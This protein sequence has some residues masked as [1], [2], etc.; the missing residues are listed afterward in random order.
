MPNCKLQWN[1]RRHKLVL[2]LSLSLLLSF[3]P[4]LSLSLSCQEFSHIKLLPWVATEW[5]EKL[6]L[7]EMR[8]LKKE[9]RFLFVFLSPTFSH[10]FVQYSWFVR[11]SLAVS[12]SRKFLITSCTPKLWKLLQQLRIRSSLLSESPEDHEPVRIRDNFLP[13]CLQLLVKCLAQSKLALS[14]YWRSE[15]VLCSLFDLSLSL[16]GKWELFMF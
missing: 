3:P 15:W 12:H 14:I 4:S 2:T 5:V 9:K 13:P 10:L 1:L 6:F 11:L 8:S 7:T 16:W